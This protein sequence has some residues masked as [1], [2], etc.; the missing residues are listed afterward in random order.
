[1]L[2][3]R[4]SL[5]QVETRIASA[6]EAWRAE[7]RPLIANSDPAQLRLR[8]EEYCADPGALKSLAI[9]SGA[10]TPVLSRWLKLPGA[11]LSFDQML[12]ICR[13]GGPGAGRACA[14]PN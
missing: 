4:A 8:I 6:D 7:C 3:E 14:G 9:R 2:L 10:T 5:Q 13:T 12:D 1:M 11:R